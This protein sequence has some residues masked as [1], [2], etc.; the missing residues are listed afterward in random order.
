MKIC[1]IIA[2]LENGGAERVLA[3]LANMLC[4]KF[5]VQIIKF[6]DK[7]PFYKLNKS[8][9]LRCLK[10]FKFDTILNKIISRFRKFFALK[11]AMKQSKADIFIS[12]L[13]T[14]N[15]ICIGA[16]FFIK[17]PLIICEHS[18]ES[19]L[20]SP[21]FR[22]L[23]R[24][25]YP[26]CDALTVLNLS[27]KNYYE[28]FVKKVIIM[29]N[30]C[31]FKICKD[32]K[33]ENL[34][35]FVGRL[36]ANKNAKMFIKAISNLPPNLRAKYEFCIAGKGELK[37]ELKNLA[38]NL[39]VKI[40]FLGA[41]KDIESL[42]E[43]AKILCL[44]SFVEGLPSVLIEAAFFKIGRISTNFTNAESLINSGFDGFLVEKN[45]DKKMSEILAN[46]MQNEKTL[47]KITQNAVKICEKFS[48]K[49]VK[50]EWLDLIAKISKNN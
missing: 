17:K 29:P 20:K 15:I 48:T 18:I 21:F 42:Y 32:L 36:D 47:S 23:R 14:T 39:G 27:D 11:N 50:K 40:N 38:R 24:I 30:P 16:N 9:N 7:K 2:T 22:S 5:E 26:F 41:I 34:V 43:R 3:T 10:P 33:K 25:F 8:V 37:D 1:F 6:D 49:S 44:C 19:Y 12:F 46:L 31:E 45:D 13:D 35:I 28:K 4:A